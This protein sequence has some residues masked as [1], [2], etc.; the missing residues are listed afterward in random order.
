MIYFRFLDIPAYFIAY[1]II[2]FFGLCIGSF[3]NVCIYRLPLEDPAERSLVKR[4]SHCPKCGAKIRFYDNV[5]VF[6]W[7]ILKGKCRNCKEPISKRY[8]LVESLNWFLYMLALTFIDVMNYPVHAILIALFFSVLIVIGFID[9][10]TMEIYPSQLGLIVILAVL[11]VIFGHT[12]TIPQRIIG[13]LAISV[14]F[15][16]IGEVSRIFIK[17][18]YGEDFRGIELGDTFLMLV[19]GL[20]IGPKCICASALI[21]IFTAAIVGIIAKAKGKESKLAFGPYLA[22]GLVFGSL[23]GNQMIDWY[24]NML[25]APEVYSMLLR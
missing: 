23:F 25:K 21:G 9:Y 20:L 7:L 19:S 17:K 22:I 5:P 16:I 6:S 14:P 12:I 10:D 15:F 1:I 2:S 18:K 11:D 8:P 13:A 24:L 4:S 3:L